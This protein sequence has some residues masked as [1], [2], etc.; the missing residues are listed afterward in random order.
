M[1]SARGAWLVATLRSR[2]KLRIAQQTAEGLLRAAVVC[3]PP[4]ARAADALVGRPRLNRGRR[5]RYKLLEAAVGAAP[6]AAQPVFP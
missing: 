4:A 1:I 2:E 3:V 6:A 5:A